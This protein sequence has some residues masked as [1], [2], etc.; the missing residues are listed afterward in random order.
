MSHQ[1]R[2]ILFFIRVRADLDCN[3][4]LS[5]SAGSVSHQTIELPNESTYAVRFGKARVGAAGTGGVP[6]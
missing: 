3:V 1:T 5:C 4:L 2:R 6:R